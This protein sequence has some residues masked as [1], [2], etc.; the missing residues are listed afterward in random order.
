M[1][2]LGIFL[3]DAS[4]DRKTGVSSISLIEKTT[5]FTS[6][7]QGID[8]KNIFEAELY[9]IKRCLIYAFKKFKN[10]I[11]VCDNKF[12]VFSAKKAF[13]EELKL[14]SRFNTVQF[15]WLPRDYMSEI[16]FLTKHVEDIDLNHKLKKEGII[17]KEYSNV[18]DIYVSEQDILERIKQEIKNILNIPGFNLEKIKSKN[19]YNL[20]TSNNEYNKEAPEI[21]KEDIL[22]ILTLDPKQKLKTSSLQIILNYIH[23]LNS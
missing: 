17:Q 10:V 16:D 7:E 22:Y 11:V 12:A 8:C 1:D 9:G 6:N 19:L 13:F 21:I 18:L 23:N 20:L 3:T 2:N 14:K 4:F 5:K 15:L